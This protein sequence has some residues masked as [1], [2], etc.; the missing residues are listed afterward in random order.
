MDTSPHPQRRYYWETARSYHTQQ[1]E[2]IARACFGVT[3]IKGPV[4]GILYSLENSIQNRLSDRVALLANDRETGGVQGNH[5]GNASTYKGSN[6]ISES[7]IYT[8][9][10]VD[11]QEEYDVADRGAC[12]EDK[13]GG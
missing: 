2:E 6:Q 13:R 11:T 10:R 1:G 4:L 12:A 3:V 8:A 5:Y 7:S 9:V